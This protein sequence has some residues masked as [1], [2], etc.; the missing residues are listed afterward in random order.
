MA[1]GGMK[2]PGENQN[3]GP[4]ILQ[5]DDTGS[6]SM[7]EGLS[8]ADASFELSGDDLH[9]TWPDGSRAS[10]EDFST[11]TPSLS[12]GQG[13]SLSGDMTLQLAQVDVPQAPGSV[14][15]FDAGSEVL[16]GTDGSSIGSVD[17]VSGSVWAVRVDGTRVELNVGDPVYQGDTLESGADGS[18]SIILVDETTFSMGEEGL[19]VLDEMI[20]DPG[21]QE[22]SISL[23]ALEGVF[24]FVSGQVAKTDP[25]A[26]TIDTPVAT[27]GIRG[28]QVG[29]NLEDEGGM[30]VILMEEADGFVGEVVITNDGGVVILNTAF[31]GSTVGDF[32]SA[33]ADSYEVD[34][35]SF[36]QDFGAALKA[37]PSVNNANT[38]GVNEIN[39][40]LLI[41]EAIQEIQEIEA[42]LEAEAEAEAESELAEELEVEVELSDSA[43]DEA[44][45]TEL[46]EAK[47]KAEAEAEALAL[48]EAQEAADAQA[49]AEAEAEVLAQAQAEAEALALAEENARK[50]AQ[51]EAEAEALILEEDARK[52]AQADADA[53]AVA[54]AQA[55]ATVVEEERRDIV[56]EEVIEEVVD[57]EFQLTTSADGGSS[58]GV[59]MKA[60]GGTFSVSD[61][62]DYSVIGGAGADTILLGGGTD[63]IASGAGDDLV[64]AGGGNDIISGGSGLG[65]DTYIGGEGV[66]W[67]IYPSAKD[68]YD[69]LINLGAEQF[70]T[71]N[72]S[73]VQLDANSA[74]D[75]SSD[76]DLVWIENDILTSIENVM[77]GEGDDIITGSAD[78]NVLVGNLGDDAL[79]GGAGDDTLI[80]GSIF[81]NADLT[82][83]GSAY[84]GQNAVSGGG[85]SDYLS[86][87]SG[88]D[89][90]LYG[91]SF[92]DYTFSMNADDLVQVHAADGS[93]DTL[94]DVE[95]IKFA[96]G[97]TLS[98]G[99]PPTLTVSAA[100]GD[101]NSAIPLDISASFDFGLDDLAAITISG[102]PSGAV[103]M[104]GSTVISIDNSGSAT[105]SADQLTGLTFTPASDS[106]GTINLTVTAD[107]VLSATGSTQTLSIDVTALAS[108]PELSVS[109]NAI[110][111]ETANSAQFD[112]S[113]VTTDSS[114]VI[115]SIQISGVPT[116]G[117]L[118]II[119]DG[120]IKVQMAVVNGVAT[121]SPT[122]GSSVVVETPNGY[123]GGD[124]SLTVTSTST[125]AGGGSTATTSVTVAVDVPD[126]SDTVGTD[127]GETLSGTTGGE[128]I[129]GMDGDDIITG[130]GG[131]DTL[132]AG[133]GNDTVTGGAQADTIDGG[134]GIDT[135]VGGGGD[136]NITGGA[137]DDTLS[138]GSGADTFEFDAN[139]GS[140]IITD[141]LAEDTIVFNGQ[142]FNAE[143]MVF[144][145]NV[146]GDVE[147]SFTGVPDSKVTLEGVKTADLDRDGDGSIEAGEGY[148]V[149][150]SGDQVTITI[151]PQS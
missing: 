109:D 113:T 61:S 92:G 130:G 128:T 83:S 44:V 68:G 18:V 50:Q 67:V 37:L 23:S 30:K 118:Y 45:A 15:S 100:A 132:Y 21:T 131:V 38:Y 137:G 58:V 108:A 142:E 99:L 151:D 2:T 112:F 143:D 91:G 3:G 82:V 79:F 24:T 104:S 25:D 77:G 127:S 27:I 101:D 66:D 111:M 107:S 16:G 40:E 139:S 149:A 39:L 80:G 87:G 119:T 98:V 59:V 78:A 103:L 122:I 73:L 138:G 1:D 9:I 146:D 51:A 110:G 126:V 60:S 5:A 136:D 94:A 7:P 22:G 8:L 62:S 105:L 81:D 11:S 116:G 54:Q 69:L 120:G 57:P 96:D 74:Q 114:E 147:I 72:G 124:F 48:A 144:S 10:I 34:K 56:V 26:M 41:E 93:V 145:E 133:G 29:L 53:E 106:G 49:E 76:P 135:I 28:T 97:G 141:I 14:I 115:S 85:G 20:Y 46:A 47:A 123:S 43:E 134:A 35:A 150:E 13:I 70:V 86:G 33:P 88:T 140:D 71:V 75:A 36:L 19:I 102:I 125:E 55:N 117:K 52:Q 42:E 17:D 121:F 89:T 90:V 129:F 12:D 32:G 63:F 6:V 4:A 148:T 65:I 95:I 84:V 64:D 31:A